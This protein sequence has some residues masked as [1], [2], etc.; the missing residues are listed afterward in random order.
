MTVQDFYVFACKNDLLNNDPTEVLIKYKASLQ[1]NS[2]N[3][4]HHDNNYIKNTG[5]N[6]NLPFKLEIIE[7]SYEDVYTLFST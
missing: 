3:E 4:A 7:Y 5:T 2:A 1:H 6:T